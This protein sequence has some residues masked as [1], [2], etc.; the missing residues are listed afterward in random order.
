M[1]SGK[2]VVISLAFLVPGNTNAAAGI[3]PALEL[4]AG[5][6]CIG[7]TFW[8]GQIIMGNGQGGGAH[9]ESQ[10]KGA[11]TRG[12]GQMLRN[13]GLTSRP[14]GSHPGWKRGEA[15]RV[16]EIGWERGTE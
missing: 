12:P 10:R 1:H 6:A 15:A 7:L 5:G 13:L 9:C 2:H 16:G 3:A 4:S 14:E 8:S 11:R